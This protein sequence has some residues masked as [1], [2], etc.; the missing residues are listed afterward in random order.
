MGAAG[1]QERAVNIRV[2]VKDGQKAVAE[3]NKLGI[4]AEKAMARVEKSSKKAAPA[5]KLVD[6]SAK[7]AHH[8]FQALG[9]SIAIIDGP[10]GGISSRFNVLAGA[11][12]RVGLLGAAGVVA[13]GLL[14][15]GF[16]AAAKAGGRMEAGLY[17]IDALI[18]ATGGSAGVTAGQLRQYGDAL[19]LATLT[20]AT[21]ARKAEGILLSFRN[22]QNDIFFGALD[23]SQDLA[24]VMGTEMSAAA[25][26]LGKALNDPIANLSALSRAGVQFSER[27]KYVIKDLIETGDLLQAQ[28]IIMAELERTLGGAAQAEAMGMAGAV[29]SLSDSWGM[30]LSEL[31]RTES[32]R[33]PVMSFFTSLGDAAQ[34]LRM[35]LSLSGVIDS[36]VITTERH[37]A[38]LE[39]KIAQVKALAPP[40]P[41]DVGFFDKARATTEFDAYQAELAKWQASLAHQR[42]KAAIEQLAQAGASFNAQ[43]RSHELLLDNIWSREQ[44]IDADILKLRGNRSA[45]ILA[46]EAKD[47]KALDNMRKQAQGDPAAGIHADPK[48]IANIDA[49][50]AKRKELTQRQLAELEKS[51]NAQLAAN[52]KVVAGLKFEAAQ[53]GLNDREQFINTKLRRLN[54]KATDGQ[55][56]A[57]E[58]LAGEIFDE[59]QA[60]KQVKD[61]MRDVERLLKKAETPR[62]RYIEQME[63]INFLLALEKIG[64]E[65]AT[66]ARREANEEL[67]RSEE[68]YRAIDDAAGDAAQAV[69]DFTGDAIHD[70]SNVG[71]YLESLGEKLQRTFT[72]LLITNPIEQYLEGKMGGEGGWVEWLFR[73]G[74]AG[75][76]APKPGGEGGDGGTVA[77]GGE[78]A[79]KSLV[80]GFM[81]GIQKATDPL[82]DMLSGF[83]K[84][85]FGGIFSDTGAFSQIASKAGDFFMQMMS[86]VPFFHEG[87]TVGRTQTRHGLVP[88]AVFAG[89][90]RL[91]GGT[92]PGLKPDEYP[93]I[94]QRDEEV[95]TRSQAAAMMRGGGREVKVEMNVYGVNDPNQW[96]EGQGLMVSDLRGA[97]QRAERDN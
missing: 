67:R 23:R 55:R 34:G 40:D 68:A 37:I 18:K 33:N 42:Q 63:Q 88:A 89:A 47:L 93:A 56:K 35:D 13:L 96:D 14:T 64:L 69:A 59:V 74:G 84:N 71:D 30:L 5:L 91:H 87:G 10:L 3:L 6:K 12:G 65:E 70:I 43:S 19:A 9:S 2:S 36:T 62:D 49:V 94:L 83:F 25:L 54:A 29:D 61:A 24:A 86:Y 4:G 28:T 57:V 52:A 76:P 81:S 38:L 75:A 44:K 72:D 21:E 92:M 82:T 46:Q 80:S 78:E 8:S 7:G 1:T 77:K 85:L 27:Q 16:V 95:L 31:G 73:N 48:A 15:A 50:I 45:K 17:R 22:I 32:V 51:T 66:A 58:K 39:A 97:I 53:F 60:E 26:Q 41:D 20:N 79:S 11:V 90:P